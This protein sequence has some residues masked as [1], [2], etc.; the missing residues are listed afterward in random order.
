MQQL[1]NSQIDL[2]PMGS[3]QKVPCQNSQDLT[4]RAR[5]RNSKD[6]YT[7]DH[8]G[9]L[10]ELTGFQHKDPWKTITWSLHVS[11]VWSFQ[12]F[13]ESSHD[14]CTRALSRNSGDLK[15]THTQ[16][17]P[18]LENLETQMNLTAVQHCPTFQLAS[19]GNGQNPRGL[20]TT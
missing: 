5:K 18:C 2:Q 20:N 10:G 6:L 9:P 12:G 3:L 8:K 1:S 13:C 4:A 19:S 15:I 7:R 11:A 14:L 17:S 16:K